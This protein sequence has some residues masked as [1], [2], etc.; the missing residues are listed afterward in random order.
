MLRLLLALTP[1][2][3]MHQFGSGRALENATREHVEVAATM[4]IIDELVGRLEPPV[5]AS[6][7]PVSASEAGVASELAA[8]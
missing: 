6:Q 4:A 5:L 8:A 1:A 3:L 7:V 2:N